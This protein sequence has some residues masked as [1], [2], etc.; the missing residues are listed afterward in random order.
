MGLFDAF[1]GQPVIDAANK[2]AGAATAG[3]NAGYGQYAPLAQAGRTA[4]T[5]NYNKGTTALAPFAS[6][7]TT[8][9][10]A[11]LDALGLNGP[12]GIARAQ[13]SFR[14]SP[15]YDF[16]FNQGLDAIDR[17]AASRGM[18][19]SGNTN[20]DT[21][22][23]A[24]GIADQDWNSYLDRLLGVTDRGQN[25]AGS[26]ANLYAGLGTGLNNSYGNQAQTAYGTQVGIGNA[27]AGA[28]IA[29]GNAKMQGNAYLWGALINGGKAL[30]G[31]AGYGLP[32]KGTS[33]IGW[34]PSIAG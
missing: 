1:T 18:L 30:A 10:P 7:G 16:A 9:L 28:D 14:T 6:A 23:F 2:A 17:R 19:S 11:Y 31:I 32:S 21:I 22:N 15:G 29:A 4:L 25:A 34:S 26:T 13:S 24:H 33:P 12:E 27:N 20:I 8:A 3:Y 5:T